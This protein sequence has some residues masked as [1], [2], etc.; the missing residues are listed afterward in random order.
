MRRSCE[1]SDRAPRT[2]RA[3]GGDKY[4]M[5]GR[6]TFP[7]EPTKAPDEGER[8]KTAITGELYPPHKKVGV[9]TLSIC[10]CDLFWAWGG[11]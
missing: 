4:G 10:E 9:R 7:E 6:G 2:P 3:P 1:R 11:S 5:E 8:R